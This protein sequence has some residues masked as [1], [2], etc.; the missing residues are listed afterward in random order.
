M[1]IFN[2]IKQQELHS[3]A[4]LDKRFWEEDLGREYTRY[5]LA[6]F[7]PGDT[8]GLKHSKTIQDRILEY[9]E[10]EKE[11]KRRKIK[12]RSMLG[13]SDD[14]DRNEPIGSIRSAGYTKPKFE[15]DLGNGRRV[16][17]RPVRNSKVVDFRQYKK[18]S[19]GHELV[20]AV[21]LNEREFEE[22]KKVAKNVDEAVEEHLRIQ[23]RLSD[24]LRI[25]VRKLGNSDVVDLR[26]FNM[27]KGETIPGPQRWADET[28]GMV[29][30]YE[31]WNRFLAK[32]KNIAGALK[33]MAFEE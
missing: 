7:K 14:F 5:E 9:L 17:I 3:R 20:A 15:I 28:R 6:T 18:H 24:N 11:E 25:A 4:E 12:L 21:S 13:K 8:I 16:K 26:R 1:K 30:Y 32:I 23:Y 22:L 29:M 27:K 2:K 19:R 33:Y 10:K 31:H